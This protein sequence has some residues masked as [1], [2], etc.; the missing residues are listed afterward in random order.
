MIDTV[1]FNDKSWIP[2]FLPH[3]EQLHVIERYRRPDLAHLNIDISIEDPGTSRSR[4]S[5]TWSGR[6]L[7]VRRSGKLSAKT[8][9]TS[10]IRALS[11]E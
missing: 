4:D 1:G 10:G 3:T 11:N 7:R 9:N 8:T 5:F 2:A 6:W